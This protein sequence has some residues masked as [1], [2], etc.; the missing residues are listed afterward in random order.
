[1]SGYCVL[2]SFSYLQGWLRST[3][4]PQ[5]AEAIQMVFDSVF[6]GLLALI[7]QQLNPKMNLLQINVVKQV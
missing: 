1:M 3:R 7:Y 2:V 4:A 6:D 5:E